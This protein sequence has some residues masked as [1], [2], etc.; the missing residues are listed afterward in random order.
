M[1]ETTISAVVLGI[2]AYIIVSQNSRNSYSAG[3]EIGTAVAGGIKVA[4]PIAAIALG[5]TLM[6]G[7]K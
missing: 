1:N 3:R 7:A 5:A 4:V 2:A 6:K